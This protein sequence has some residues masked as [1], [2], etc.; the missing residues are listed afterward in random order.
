MR[1]WAS[2]PATSPLA[3]SARIKNAQV[4]GGVIVNAGKFWRFGLEYAAVT[5]TS[6]GATAGAAST[7]EKAT[8]LAVSSMLKF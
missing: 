4:S 3:A 2:A 1:A 6:K 5:T 8:Q 7:E